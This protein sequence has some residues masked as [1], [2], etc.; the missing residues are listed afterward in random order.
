MI[1]KFWTI[2]ANLEINTIKRP[3]DI[4]GDEAS[5]ESALIHTVKNII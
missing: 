5:S 1:T 4:S 2:V 3:K